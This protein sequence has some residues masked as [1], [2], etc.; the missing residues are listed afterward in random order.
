[1]RGLFWPVAPQLL[2]QNTLIVIARRFFPEPRKRFFKNVTV[3]GTSSL[4]EIN[5]D[6]RKLKTPA[7]NLV[8]IPNYGLAL[9]V[10]NE[11]SAVKEK[12]RPSLMHLT[13]LTNTV[14]DNPGRTTK[15][16]L[17]GK[18]LDYVETDTLLFRE[19][20]TDDFTQLQIKE[21]DPV[22]NWFNERFET[23]LKPCH[24]F[25]A[26]EVSTQTKE[27]I[28]R[29]L[30]SY[31]IWAVNGLLYGIE[32][33]RSVIL[34]LAAAERKISAVRAVE[35][36]RLETIFQTSQW[37]SVEWGHDLE[38]YDAE[39]RFSAALLFTHLNTWQASVKQKL[40]Q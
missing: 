5:L 35:L 36:S 38:R 7:G 17:S 9:A 37:G 39:S 34:T 21:W 28:R 11:W 1:M 6:H 19:D 26:A 4:Y 32:A 22:L 23:D 15:Y 13:G 12:I 29:Y 31:D 18:I 40:K 33:L 8:Q 2:N 3:A 25:Q 20:G 24:G 30:L 27:R 14:L 16:D 10:A